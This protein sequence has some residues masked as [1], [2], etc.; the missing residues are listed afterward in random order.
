LWIINANKPKCIFRVELPDEN[1]QI[2]NTYISESNDL[3]II[4]EEEFIYNLYHIDLDDQKFQVEP[5]MS[6]SKEA[7]GKKFLNQIHVRPASSSKDI[8]GENQA[9]IVYFLHDGCLYKW[10]QGKSKENLV[11]KIT[12]CDG[13]FEIVMNT[14]SRRLQKIND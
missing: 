3:Y 9:L 13:N 4:C 2:A 6:Y 12:G 8:I 5:L 10:N 7:V 1:L 11:D 14:N